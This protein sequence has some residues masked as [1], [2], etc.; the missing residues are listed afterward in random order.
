MTQ[1]HGA[2]DFTTQRYSFIIKQEENEGENTELY[3][4]HHCK[5]TTPHNLLMQGHSMEHDPVKSLTFICNDCEAHFNGND[6][7][8]MCTKHHKN[9]HSGKEVQFSFTVMSG[10][11]EDKDLV[12][13][14]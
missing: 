14:R 4:C 1:S 9:K 3:V 6:A 5:F 8:A 2:P 10:T 7:E 11:I 13:S 12:E